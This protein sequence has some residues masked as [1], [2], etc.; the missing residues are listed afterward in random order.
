MEFC[1]SVGFSV[2]FGGMLSPWSVWLWAV[3]G[4]EPGCCGGGVGVNGASV[5]VQG[6]G[7]EELGVLGILDESW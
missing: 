7:G 2:G 4:V 1:L 5:L 3:R 6:T